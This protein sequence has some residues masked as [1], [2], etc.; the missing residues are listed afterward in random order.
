MKQFHKKPDF[1][2]FRELLYD[3]LIYDI[4]ISECLYYMYEY[5]VNAG[6]I[7]PTDLKDVIQQSAEQLKLYNNNY[8]PIYHLERIFYNIIRHLQHNES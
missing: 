2:Q 3:I 4:N 8:R 6:M 5:F 1:L 7:T